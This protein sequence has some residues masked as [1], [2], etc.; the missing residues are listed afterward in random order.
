MVRKRIDKSSA[1]SASD[2]D[3][4]KNFESSARQKSRGSSLMPVL[5]RMTRTQLQFLLK[6]RG[7]PVSGNKKN[8]VQDRLTL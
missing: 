2:V 8:M 7:L 6:E 3:G 1:A 5:R 4:A